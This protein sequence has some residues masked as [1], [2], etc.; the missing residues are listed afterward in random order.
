MNNKQK[1]QLSQPPQTPNTFL[2]L[3][4]PFDTPTSFIKRPIPVK[5]PYSKE[6]N[7]AH[8]SRNSS[9]GIHSSGGKKSSRH[10]SNSLHNSPD[11]PR[12]IYQR[13]LSFQQINQTSSFITVEKENKPPQQNT[14]TQQNSDQNKFFNSPISRRE[15]PNKSYQ[16]AFASLNLGTTTLN[17]QRSFQNY[18]NT[19]NQCQAQTDFLKTITQSPM[20]YKNLNSVDWRFNSPHPSPFKMKANDSQGQPIKSDTEIPQNIMTRQSYQYSLLSPAPNFDTNGISASDNL[21]NVLKYTKDKELTGRRLFQSPPKF[22]P[23]LVGATKGGAKIYQNKLEDI[24]EEESG[25]GHIGSSS[26][27]MNNLIYSK[28]PEQHNHHQYNESI[29]GSNLIETNFNRKRHQLTFDEEDHLFAT[30]TMDQNCHSQIQSTSGFYGNENKFNQSKPIN[31][32]NSHQYNQIRQGYFNGQY[33]Q[34][35]GQQYQNEFGHNFSS[36]KDFQQC[37]QNHQQCKH[38]SRAYRSNVIQQL[39]LNKSNFYPKLDRINIKQTKN[40][41]N[42]IGDQKDL[43]M[44]YID[45]SV[46]NAHINIQF[47]NVPQSEMQPM[48]YFIQQEN[49]MQDPMKMRTFYQPMGTC[50][51]GYFPMTIG[52]QKNYS[53]IKKQKAGKK[54]QLFNQN[55]SG[56]KRSYGQFMKSSGKKSLMNLQINNLGQVSKSAQ[57]QNF[58]RSMQMQNSQ[59]YYDN[60]PEAV[61]NEMLLQTP[62]GLPLQSTPDKNQDIAQNSNFKTPN[63]LQSDNKSQQP[64]KTTCNCKKSKCLKLYCDCF[65]VGLGCSPECNCMDCANQDDNEERKLAMEAIV[66]RNPNAFKPKIQEKGY[67]AK[68]CHCKKSGCLKKYC[69]CYQSGVPCTNICACEGCKNCDENMIGQRQLI[70]L[71]Q[72]DELAQQTFEED[73]MNSPRLVDEKDYKNHIQNSDKKSQ[74]KQDEPPNSG[75]KISPGKST[76]RSGNNASMMQFST[77]EDPVKQLNDKITT[78]RIKQ[79]KITTKVEITPKK[80]LTFKSEVVPQNNYLNLSSSIDAHQSQLETRSLKRQKTSTNSIPQETLKT[81]NSTLLTAAVGTLDKLNM[82]KKEQDQEVTSTTNTSTQMTTRSKRKQQENYSTTGNNSS[83]NKK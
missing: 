7:V 50:E 64:Q 23:S 68:G 79:V 70:G 26:S 74:E 13:S 11:P 34:Q 18:N 48:G 28:E 77:P 2:S 40:E 69:E 15:S 56:V 55:N 67:H 60:T 58:K 42:F 72:D 5:S 30:P 45:Q 80:E 4:Q 62:K 25:L 73:K 8:S 1:Q 20:L 83:H 32:N 10:L 61:Q 21:S 75:N 9:E 16:Q 31:Q 36:Q 6:M 37:D 44:S 22:K 52:K 51:Q 78:R 76:R 19:Q 82:H 12:S 63:I 29:N 41:F 27:M 65:A 66:E 24:I 35:M 33:P 49:N 39:D 59:R 17:H 57:K 54:Q 46:I 47:Q 53:S 71:E 38:S 3:A 14:S 43:N 81:R